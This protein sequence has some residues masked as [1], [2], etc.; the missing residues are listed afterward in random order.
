MSEKT[1][2]PTP[3]KIRDARK[4]GQVPQSRE[5]VSAVLILAFF[6]YILGGSKQI[7]GRI[8]DSIT[9]AGEI[10]YLPFDA[11]FPAMLVLTLTVVV[12]ILLPAVAIVLFFAIGGNV[13]Q[14]GFLVAPE[15]L[16]PNLGALNPAQGVKKIFALRSLFELIKSIIKIGILSILVWKVI[17]DGVGASFVAPHCG[18]QCSVSVFHSQMLR[19]FI[20]AG[21]AF[22]AVAVADLFFQRKQY[23]KQLM[24]SKDE[25]KREF[26]E[27]E[28]D[29]LI[30]GK[31][32]QAHQE[33]LQAQEEDVVRKSSVVVTNPQHIAVA[34][35][36]HQDKTPLPIIAAKGEGLHAA[37][38]LKIA[39]KA[40]VP[41]MRA[42]PLARSLYHQVD[43]SAYIPRDIIEPVAEILR[44]AES[45]R[46]KAT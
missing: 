19:L 20:Y 11:A 9:Q 21:L 7:I 8:G 24:M 23:T 34:L 27:M 17:Y 46:A 35:F 44:W 25:I 42:A 22:S 16:K 30:K 41:I 32:K 18:L 6:F 13:S 33:I 1:E 36:Y 12:Q 26:K 38:I 5:I 29:P 10:A 40:G 28:G 15:K 45:Y 14:F 4:K 2:P 43:V 39:K 37:R 31:R 3:K